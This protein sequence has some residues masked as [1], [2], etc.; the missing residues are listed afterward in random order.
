MPRDKLKDLAL[1][2]FL[3]IVGIFAFISVNATEQTR[4]SSGKAITYATMP[5]IWAGLLTL[6]ALLFMANALLEILAERQQRNEGE[7]ISHPRAM[8]WFSGEKRIVIVR[9]TGTLALLLIYIMLLL[10][11]NFAVLTTAFLFLMF[12]LY[13]QTSVIQNAFI[14]ICGGLGFYLLFI[15][16]LKIPLS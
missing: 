3:L 8:E 4:I 14:A 9:T 7:G 5:S 2:C 15:Y 11:V 13:G 10:H 6:L 16:F 12:Y 1:G